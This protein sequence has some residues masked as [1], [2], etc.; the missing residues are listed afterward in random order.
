MSP[1]LLLVTRVVEVEERD[2]AFNRKT[3][4]FLETP[5]PPL[6]LQPASLHRVSPY[7]RLVTGVGEGRVRIRI[8]IDRKTPA[9]QSSSAAMVIRIVRE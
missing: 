5:G 7:L 9:L 6:H 2:I 8:D 1:A 3:K 4:V